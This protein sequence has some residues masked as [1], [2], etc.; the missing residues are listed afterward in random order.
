[1]LLNLGFLVLRSVSY[2]FYSSDWK[3]LNYGQLR[4]GLGYNDIRCVRIP[5]G[6]SIV[7]DEMMGK[8]M[9]RPFLHM[10]YRAS[11]IESRKLKTWIT[12]SVGAATSDLDAMTVTYLSER[13]LVVQGGNN[14]I[15]LHK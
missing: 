4:A 12:D 9:K 5:A 6:K 7:Y 11:N 15:L 14:I 13:C 1:M 10:R 2:A 8:N 3:Y